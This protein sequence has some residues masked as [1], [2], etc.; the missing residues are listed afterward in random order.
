ME[1]RLF[2]QGVDVVFVGAIIVAVFTLI[3]ALLLLVVT[4]GIF[5]QFATPDLLN[6]VDLGLAEVYPLADLVSS[7]NLISV[8]FLV[9]LTALVVDRLLRDVAKLK[10]DL[11]DLAHVHTTSLTT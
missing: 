11:R 3:R 7:Q 8:G 4:V 1:V 2:K 5:V 10:G 6:L 9:I